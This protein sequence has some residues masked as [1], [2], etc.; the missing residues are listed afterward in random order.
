MPLI[1]VYFVTDER[2]LLLGA[3]DFGFTF[4]TRTPHSVEINT[5]FG[6]EK[7]EILNVLDFTSARKRMSVIVK[8]AND[9]IILYCKVRVPNTNLISN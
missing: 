6:R 7:Y 9:K 8:T 4:D 1:I 3:Q 5:L 2:A